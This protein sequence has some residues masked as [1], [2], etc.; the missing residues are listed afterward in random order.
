MSLTAIVFWALYSCGLLAALIRPIVGIVIYILVYHL[1]PEDQ[2]WGESVRALGMRTSLV[3]AIATTIGILMHEQDFALSGRQITL[4]IRLFVLFSL[5]TIASIAWGPA[6]TDRS[7]VQVE[8][9]AKVIVFVVLLATCVRTPAHYHLVILAWLA[10]VLYIGYEANG[11]VGEYSSGRLTGG[12]GGS[13]F[14]DSSGLAVHLVA[15][16][17]LAGAMIFIARRWWTRG[18]MLLIGALAVNTIILTRTRNAL[19][20]FGALLLVGLLSLPRRFRLAGLLAIVGGAAMTIHLADEKWWHRMETMTDFQDDASAAARIDYWKAAAQMAADYP[21][22]IGIGKFHL[23]VMDYVDGLAIERSAHSTFMTCL[24][25]LGSPG[26]L[27]FLAIVGLCMRRMS[28]ISRRMPPELMSPEVRIGGRAVGF[29][30]AWHAMAIRT[31]LAGYLACG[32]F[33]T[34][35]WAADLWMLLGLAACLDRLSQ[36]AIE[37]ARAPAEE[38]VSAPPPADGAIPCPAAAL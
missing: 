14:A 17:P 21:L 37:E 36:E 9:F 18:L 34:R 5:I 23:T 7:Y 2:W 10:G 13:D 29:H 4:P 24:A 26:L 19:V 11:G 20:G 3:A 25:E 12:L 33:T 28:R 16:L 27:L 6:A 31:A 35:L 38:A 15:S 8:K 1:N 30:Y 32:L 22:G